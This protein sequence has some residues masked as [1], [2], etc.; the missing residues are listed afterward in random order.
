M[1]GVKLGVAIEVLSFLR[2][3][4][5]RLKNKT[6]SVKLT[7]EEVKNLSRQFEHQVQDH[8]FFEQEQQCHRPNKIQTTHT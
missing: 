2:F 7:I 1:M 5:L 8:L 6:L 4:L 3:C